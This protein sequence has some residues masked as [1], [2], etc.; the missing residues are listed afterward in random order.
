MPSER[1]IA[2]E[3]QRLATIEARAF[4]RQISKENAISIA[5]SFVDPVFEWYVRISLPFSYVSSKNS[6]HGYRGHRNGKVKYLKP[7]YKK[8]RDSIAY[9][10]HGAVKSVNIK[11]NKIWI[12]IHVE[13]PNH[14]GDAVNVVDTVCDAIKIAI[15]IDDRW[16]SIRRLDWSINKDNP[17]LLIGVGQESG[18][19]N[20]KTCHHCGIIK[21]LTSFTKD[22]NSRDGHGGECKS[23]RL[24]VS[25]E[26]LARHPTRRTWR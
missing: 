3:N 16:Y 7:E 8:Y 15:P 17:Q 18:L 13:K 19:E 25:E 9:S 23:C 5:D 12:D 14:Y 21:P 24:R 4:G 20:S 22:R 11:V 2:S 1:L 26:D 10:L 6:A